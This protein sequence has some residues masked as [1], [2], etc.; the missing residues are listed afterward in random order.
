MGLFVSR[1]E[2][3]FDDMDG[4]WIMHHSRH[5]MHLERA[6]MQMFDTIMET[7]GFDPVKFPDAYVVVKNIDIHFDEPLDAIG[8]FL[9]SLQVARLREAG[10][11]LRFG[12]HSA[13]GK[14]LFAH[15]T[16]TVCKLSAAT[17]QPAGWTPLFRER[18][19]A[20][21]AAARDLPPLAGTPRKR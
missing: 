4:L 13:D 3:Y 11:T 8:P 17:K 10:L 6:Q 18:Y 19:S 15:G 20:W 12:F 2:A 14:R 1:R 16:R 9:I 5:I 21:E 7:G